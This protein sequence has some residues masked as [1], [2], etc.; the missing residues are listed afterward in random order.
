MQQIQKL[1]AILVNRGN[2]TSK[3]RITLQAMEYKAEKLVADGA[4]SDALIEETYKKTQLIHGD[5]Q[6]GNIICDPDTGGIV[7]L[8]DMESFHYAP[9]VWDLGRACAYIFQCRLPETREFLRGYHRMYPLTEEEKVTWVPVMEDY[10]IKSLWTC[11]EY[12]MNK[13]S[14]VDT[15]GTVAAYRAIQANRDEFLMMLQRNI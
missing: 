6:M 15:Y 13:T 10:L 14:S 9:R 5:F 3:D 4:R 7:G 8:I 12:V 11:H 2:L 1:Q